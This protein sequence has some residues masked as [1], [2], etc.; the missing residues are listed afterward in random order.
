MQ[1]SAIIDSQERTHNLSGHIWYWAQLINNW[2]IVTVAVEKKHMCEKV[3]FLKM[4][5]MKK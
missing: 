4:Y 1:L 5:V 2:Y 3:T